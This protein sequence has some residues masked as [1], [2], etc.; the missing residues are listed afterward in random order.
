MQ[1]FHL[2]WSFREASDRYGTMP[3]VSG[4]IEN[5]ILHVFRDFQL[6]HCLSRLST[7]TFNFRDFQLQLQHFTIG[8]LRDW[9]FETVEMVFVGL[10]RCW[11]RLLAIIDDHKHSFIRSHPLL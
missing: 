7:P 11:V 4:T 9:H 5:L 6:Q 10:I 3:I 8:Y 2:E 1:I